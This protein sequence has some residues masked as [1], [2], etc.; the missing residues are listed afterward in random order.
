MVAADA[1]LFIVDNCLELVSF[2]FQAL[3]FSP[4]THRNGLFK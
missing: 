3:G 1:P 2:Y 4:P